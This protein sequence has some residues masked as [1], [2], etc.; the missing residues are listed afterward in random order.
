MM[1]MTTL[2]PFLPSHP[3]STRPPPSPPP[4]TSAQ[5]DQQVDPRIRGEK[6]GGGGR[7]D[8][9]GAGRE[10]QWEERPL[11]QWRDHTC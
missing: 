6:G 5:G 4:A 9:P 1:V 2:S 7:V 8:S 10:Q 3:L 11:G